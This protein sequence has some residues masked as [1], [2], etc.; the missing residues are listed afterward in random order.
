MTQ[1]PTGPSPARGQA[2]AQFTVPAKHPMVTVLG[3][4]DALLRVIEKAFP[5]ADIHVRG[6]EIS[7][8]GDPAEVAL[9]QRL[10]DEMMLV[11]RT[12]QPMTEDA[13]ERSIAML[14]AS[15]EGT[16]PEETPAEVL[17]Q[18]ILSSR[19]RTIR[20]KTLNQKRYVDAID[21][22]TVIFGIGPAGTG[23]TYLAMAKAVQALQ[24][25]QVN[26]IILTRPAVEAGERLGFLPGTL[27]EKIDPY[28]R[29]LYDALHDMLD[30]DSIPRLMAAGTIEVAPLAYM[31]GRT[32]NDAFIILDEAQNTN[33]EQMK[34]FLTRLGF[35]SK[36]VITG[37][38]TQVDLPSGTKSG[39]RQ[40]QDILEGVDDVHFSRLTSEDVVRHKLV[41]RIVEAYEKYDNRDGR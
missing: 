16:G 38:V 24:S 27:Y 11:L 40:V 1:T 10:F 39:L 3:S 14:R 33:P 31:R 8:T 35:E 26:R 9:V 19:G 30:P 21:K 15:E 2:R 4:G 28:L 5:A 17:T 25:K 41:G 22:H 20:P 23:K 34:M 32:L 12:G 18:N 7:A 29:P 6:N 37:D 36:I 13:V